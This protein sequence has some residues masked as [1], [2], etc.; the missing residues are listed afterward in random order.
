[1]RIFKTLFRI[2]LLTVILGTSYL[3]YT[4]LSLENLDGNL[5]LKE[6]MTEIKQFKNNINLQNKAIS[7][8]AIGW[9][10]DHSLLTINSIYETLKKSDT[11]AYNPSFNF[12][13]V[14]MFSLGRIPR[15]R[16]KAPEKVQ[17]KDSPSIKTIEEQIENAYKNLNRSDALPQNSNFVHPYIGQLNRNEAKRFLKIHTLHHLKICRDILEAK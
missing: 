11:T 9:H 15:G 6:E 10:L 14:I 13:K 8:A 17:P 12:P 2:L 1:M 4:Y 16:A 3:A 7:K 5:F